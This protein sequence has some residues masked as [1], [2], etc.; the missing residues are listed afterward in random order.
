MKNILKSTIL[1]LCGTFVM[2]SCSDDRENNPVL[3][4]PT[5]FTM[6]VPTYS[7][8][9]IDLAT[10]SALDFTW[11]QPAYGYPAAAEYQVQF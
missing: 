7:T 3:L 1:L 6:N 8:Q 10:S 4:S 2:A 5:T 9:T 11:S